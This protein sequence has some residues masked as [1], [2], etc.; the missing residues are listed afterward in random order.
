M[1]VIIWDLNLHKKMVEPNSWNDHVQLYEST[2]NSF[3][4][5]DIEML[6]HL[7]LSIVVTSY[8]TSPN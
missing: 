1:I 3:S 4:L 7:I 2:N 6:S 8:K 5:Y